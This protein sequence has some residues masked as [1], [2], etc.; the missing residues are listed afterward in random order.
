MYYI[1][2]SRVIDNKI[3][4]SRLIDNKCNLHSS[5]CGIVCKT[6]IG[7]CKIKLGDIGGCN[8][9]KKHCCFHWELTSNYE[10]NSELK[11]R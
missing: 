10:L 6:T 5:V 11:Q 8:I 7:L 9:D 2:H 3:H 1:G 4:L